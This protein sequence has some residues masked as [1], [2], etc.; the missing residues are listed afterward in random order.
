MGED[1]QSESEGMKPIFIITEW[2]RDLNS[3]RRFFTY[4]LF[5]CVILAVI[6]LVITVS[7]DLYYENHEITEYKQ[8]CKDVYIFNWC[9]IGCFLLLMLL[10]NVS[11]L[12][13]D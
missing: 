4:F 2:I 12:F 5:A 13:D 10:I 6:A 3:V 9:A 7:I 11:Y 8:L 1:I